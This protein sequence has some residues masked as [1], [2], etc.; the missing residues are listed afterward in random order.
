MHMPPPKHA[1]HPPARPLRCRLAAS[2]RS[3]TP[4][5]L[6]PCVDSCPGPLVFCAAS[7][8]AERLTLN[9]NKQASRTAEL[10]GLPGV[11]AAVKY[12]CHMPQEERDLSLLSTHARWAAAVPGTG[13]R[14]PACP[15]P[16]TARSLL[17]DL[18]SLCA[19]ARACLG[20]GMLV[21]PSTPHGMWA[22]RNAAAAAGGYWQPTRTP[23]W[24]CSQ[25][26][27]RRCRRR[28]CCPCSPRT[29]H[30]WQVRYRRAIMLAGRCVHAW[31]SVL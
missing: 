7:S 15:A 2:P 25:T 5:L 28:R 8:V 11:W 3:P 18:P 20:H 10:R 21:L 13:G 6:R 30:A 24:R 22:R 29:R 9:P 16:A 31:Q 12:V 19:P 17:P 27:S 1:Y 23:A 14:L 26:C 4:S